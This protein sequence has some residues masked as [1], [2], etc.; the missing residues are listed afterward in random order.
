MRIGE[1]GINYS[2]YEVNSINE[3]VDIQDVSLFSLESKHVGD[4]RSST[5]ENIYRMGKEIGYQ[6]IKLGA[7]RSEHGA[8]IEGEINL[9][10]KMTFDKNFDRAVRVVVDKDGKYW[11]DN[12]HTV[13]SYIGR[14][15]RYLS[16]IPVYVVDFRAELPK[17]IS[18]NNSIQGDLQDLR[19][20]LSSAKR[21][22][23]RNEAGWRTDDWKI[24]DLVQDIGLMKL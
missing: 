11:A 15:K 14:N 9:I 1:Y 10:L 3:I 19:N 13:I 21:I 2:Y 20:V 24:G 6:N 8:D 17:V 7:H 16:E 5:A 23:E 22:V 12:T 18:V 4:I